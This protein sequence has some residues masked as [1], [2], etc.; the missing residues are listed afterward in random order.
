MKW[1]AFS[2]MLQWV[3]LSDLLGR[4]GGSVLTQ[5]TRD[6]HS[7]LASAHNLGEDGDGAERSGMRPTLTDAET[8]CN[9]GRIQ[10]LTTRRSTPARSANQQLAWGP[11]RWRR[12]RIGSAVAK[13]CLDCGG[14]GGKPDQ[15]FVLAGSWFRN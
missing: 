14:M 13:H 4:T 8:R 1:R 3:R 11:S 2:R 12:R 7:G 5:P 10:E 9:K 6:E 15:E